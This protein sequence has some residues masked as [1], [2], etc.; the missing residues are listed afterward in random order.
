LITGYSLGAIVTP[1]ITMKSQVVKKVT[2]VNIPNA[3][4][5]S[6]ES[7]IDFTGK[8]LKLT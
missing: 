8:L 5:T 7:N 1:E 3:A 2:V 6:E 4:T